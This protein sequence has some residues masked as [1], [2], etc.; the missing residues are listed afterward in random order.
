MALHPKR[1][2]IAAERLE[3]VGIRTTKTLEEQKGAAVLPGC[4]RI[5]EHTGLR[6]ATY[7]LHKCRGAR[8]IRRLLRRKAQLEHM[9]VRHAAESENPWELPALLREERGDQ[10]VGVLVV[11]GANLPQ[12]TIQRV[13]DFIENEM[14][15]PDKFHRVL[16][17]EGEL[18]FVQMVQTPGQPDMHGDIYKL[19]SQHLGAWK[20]A[21]LTISLSSGARLEPCNLESCTWPDAHFHTVGL[22][23]KQDPQHI[24]QEG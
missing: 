21:P 1:R 16:V 9:K 23:G 19:T 24:L 8:R 14:R 22:D 3:A 15:N 20:E 5:S 4:L 17:L 12:E 6:R 13:Q 10:D 18:D 2:P 11:K 7:T